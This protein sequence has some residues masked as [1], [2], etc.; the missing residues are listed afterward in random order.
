[1]RNKNTENLQDEMDIHANTSD[2]NLEITDEEISDEII[3]DEYEDE[4]A[5]VQDD[6]IDSKKEPDDLHAY[7]GKSFFRRL[8]SYAPLSPQ[9]EYRLAKE[10][11]DNGSQ[12][13]K[14]ALVLH[15]Q[16]LVAYEASKLRNMGVDYDDL[17]QEGNLGLNHAIDKY[18]YR[19][20]NKLSTYATWWI[21]QSMYRC[22]ENQGRT[23][24]LP[25][26]LHAQLSKVKKYRERYFSEHGE[27]PTDLEVSAGVEMPL[28][29]VKSL[30]EI[31]ERVT[32]TSLSTP[33]G[34]TGDT[35]LEDL[36]PDERETK[37]NILVEVQQDSI[38]KAF[39][40]LNE[41]EAFVLTKRYGLN[42]EKPQT[43]EDVGSQL[44]LTRE[45]I[46]QIQEKAER[47]LSRNAELRNLF[48]T[49]KE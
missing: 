40:R 1:M 44:G 42:G 29:K 36:I 16:R 13:A 46:R 41:K 12:D 2:E 45:R 8:T 7:D 25:V 4:S 30:R 23:I 34:D 49:M 22:I 24:R 5:E 39:E 21:K 33:V 11:Q 48:V 43:L 38:R 26:H 28:Q 6:E 3:Q 20:G 14:D 9:E 27:Y 47:K 18:D 37:D 10:Y 19:T 32:I 35:M 31:Q 15:N 17:I